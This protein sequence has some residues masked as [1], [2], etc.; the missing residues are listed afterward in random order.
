MLKPPKRHP[1]REELLAYAESLVDKGVPVSSRIA[2]HVSRCTR[3]ADEVKG[4][5]ASLSFTASAQELEPSR[6]LATQI[7]LA[8]QQ[9][10]DLQRRRWAFPAPVRFAYMAGIVV[11]LAVLGVF[12]FRVMLGTAEERLADTAI[13][14]PAAVQEMLKLS[15][16]LE[17][18][19]MAEVNAL[20]DAVRL[21]PDKAQNDRERFLRRVVDAASADLAA[22]HD[23][24]RRYP[25]QARAEQLKR[26]A[27]D[28]QRRALRA[29]FLYQELPAPADTVGP[30][31]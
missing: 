10:K 26:D 25:L 17:R 30:D 15:P 31:H 29:L 20:A 16:A 11:G 9:Q 21:T 1:S 3:C 13:G 14:A 28:A 18:Q 2:A 5:R 22:A 6:D 23:A 19:W 7:L 8:A 12:W 24:L 4:F 27:L